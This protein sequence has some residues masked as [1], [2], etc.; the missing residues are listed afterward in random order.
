V[1]LPE[2]ALRL[3]SGLYECTGVAR[4]Q[5]KVSNVNTNM[6]P[7]TDQTHHYLRD[8]THNYARSVGQEQGS[9]I[10]ISPV[11]QRNPGTIVALEVNAG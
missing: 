1:S 7:G 4:I 2:M 9:D 6:K 8:T 10:D 11:G 3:E 5:Q